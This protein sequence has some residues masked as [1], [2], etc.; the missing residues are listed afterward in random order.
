MVYVNTVFAM[1]IIEKEDKHIN[2]MFTLFAQNWT[3]WNRNI[4][5][6]RSN[7]WSVMTNWR[8]QVLTAERD[9]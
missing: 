2:L 1:F 6:K 9:Q 3:S 8:L 5:T 4:R 7:L